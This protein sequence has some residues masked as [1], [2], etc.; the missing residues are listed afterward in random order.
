MKTNLRLIKNKVKWLSYKYLE[1]CVKYD[2]LFQNFV[3]L[4]VA[5]IG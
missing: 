2:V 4:V 5:I 3:L 1:G